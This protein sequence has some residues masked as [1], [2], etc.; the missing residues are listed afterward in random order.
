MTIYRARLPRI[1]ER[2]RIVWGWVHDQD[3]GRYP[4]R[5]VDLVSN[6]SHS[7]LFFRF[8][9]FKCSNFL[10]DSLPHRYANEIRRRLW[11]DV[12]YQEFE[13]LRMAVGHRWPWKNENL[14]PF[15]TVTG[16]DA[17]RSFKDSGSSVLCRLILIIMINN[18][19]ISIM[20]S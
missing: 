4:G 10:G 2:Q 14:S 1:T 8:V 12:Y 17:S 11:K 13:G 19:D 9:S 6:V 15:S 3:D 5:T 20:L 16:D 7:S 18:H